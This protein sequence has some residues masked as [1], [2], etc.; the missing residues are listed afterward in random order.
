MLAEYIE[1]GVNEILKTIL[2]KTGI[3]GDHSFLDGYSRAFENVPIAFNVSRK[4]YY[5]WLPSP[6]IQLPHQLGI[7]QVSPMED[8]VSAG[9]Y[10]PYGSDA[11]FGKLDGANMPGIPFA[12]YRE[13]EKLF[14][15]RLQGNCSMLMKLVP[16]FTWFKD[17]DDLPAAYAAENDIFGVCRRLMGLV[18]MTKEDAK[19]DNV[20]PATG[21]QT[22]TAMPNL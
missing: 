13:G 8:Q 9:N 1:I 21:V 18:Q 6:V 2:L 22:Q 16:P 12:Y 14:Y 19:N 4:E 5:S 3:T 11:V 10:Y 17:D 20:V 15:R 7:R